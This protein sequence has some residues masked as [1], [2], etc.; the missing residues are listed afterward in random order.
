MKVISLGELNNFADS[1]IKSINFFSMDLSL[2]S[3][4]RIEFLTFDF[5]VT[6]K[7]ASVASPR[8]LFQLAAGNFIFPL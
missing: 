6:S 1:P 3:K 8:R 2:S 5:V 7:A 4:T